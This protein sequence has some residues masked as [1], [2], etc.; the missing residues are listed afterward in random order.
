VLVLLAPLSAAGVVLNPRQGHTYASISAALAS[1]SD[2]D[3][4]LVSTGVY[5]EHV[6]LVQNHTLLGGYL[7]DFSGR[8]NDPRLTVVDAGGATNVVSTF[9]QNDVIIDGMTLTNGVAECGG[10][11]F[12]WKLMHVTLRTS[13]VAGCTATIGGGILADGTLTLYDSAVHGCQAEQGGGIAATSGTAHVT[14]AGAHTEIYHNSATDGGGLWVST[15]HISIV[16]NASV[17]GNLA[18]ARGGALFLG[19]NAQALI[20]GPGTIIGAPAPN[21]VTNTAAEGGGAYVSHAMLVVED[22]AAFHANHAPLRGGAI[23]VTSGVVVVRNGGSIGDAIG[24]VSNYAGGGGGGIA[25]VDALVIVSN[26][27]RVAHCA[28]PDG[29]GILLWNATGVF[30]RAVFS[31][32]RALLYGGGLFA[33]LTSVVVMSASRMEHN[34]AERSGGAVYLQR[35]PRTVQLGGC[36]VSNHAAIAA[37]AVYANDCADVRLGH[38]CLAYNNAPSAGAALFDGCVTVRLDTVCIASNRAP[39]YGGIV[40]RACADYELADCDVIGNVSLSGSYGVVY[41]EQSAGRVRTCDRVSDIRG[42]HAAQGGALAV[43]SNSFL[44]IEAPRMMVSIAGNTAALHGGGVWCATA[45]TVLLAGA[46]VFDGNSAVHGGGLYADDGATVT[47]LPTNGLAPLFTG[48]VAQ[49]HGGGLAVYNTSVLHAVNCAFDGNQAGG[50]GGGV[51]TY[52]SS[53][54]IHGDFAV[55]P[56]RPPCVFMHNRADYGGACYFD[57]ISDSSV[58]DALIVSNHATHAGGGV[59]AGSGGHAHLRN[60]VVAGNTAP[61][62]AGASGGI[63]VRLYAEHCTFADNSSAGVDY[64][65][66]LGLTNCIAWGNVGTQVAAG[67]ALHFC[68][69]EGGYPGTGNLNADPLFRSPDA[70]DWSL[71]VGSPSIDSA[72]SCGVTLDCRGL[73]R[74]QGYGFDMGAYEL[75]PKPYLDVTP[76]VLEFGIVNIGSSSDRVARIQCAGDGW[77]TGAL[78]NVPVPIFSADVYNY[79]VPPNS[80]TDV[81]FTFSP[82]MAY[83]WTQTVHFISNGGA[84]DI[85]L[86]GTGIPEPCFMFLFLVGLIGLIGPMRRISF[87]P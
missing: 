21:W 15:A 64:S 10:G 68:N 5:H 2:H 3:V 50:S 53:A 43:A 69:V 65:G 36:I 11:L 72:T 7:P 31:G 34:A 87:H 25:A 73:M 59:R 44:F 22:G 79:V 51:Y 48:N 82:P 23:M 26:G 27:G 67:A 14:L 55:P 61:Q 8:T 1:A 33:Y 80:A 58:R 66:V 74:P 40:I 84:Q 83:A 70:L 39:E 63:G 46:V 56:A 19:N 38:A 57:M 81:V 45:S 71:A 37:G 30:E 62:A 18:S 24:V 49:Q 35:L 86:I 85:T 78:E 32:N 12:V 60:C 54:Q 6:Y 47:A 42:N 76:L 75:D 4:F 9:G 13:I 52:W 16:S 28:A 29:G 20:S 77:L 41:I 17:W